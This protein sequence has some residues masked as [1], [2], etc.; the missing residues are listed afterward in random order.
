MY[1][2]KIEFIPEMQDR[3]ILGTTLIYFILL[4]D[5]WRKVTCSFHTC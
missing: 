3:L 5:L 4:L 2:D 1:Q